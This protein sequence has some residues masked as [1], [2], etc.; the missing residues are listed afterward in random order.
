[1]SAKK[2]IGRLDMI[3]VSTGTIVMDLLE[4]ANHIMDVVKDAEFDD[5]DERTETA[6]A[7]VGLTTTAAGRMV[8]LTRVNYFMLIGL[9]ATNAA[10]IVRE[11]WFV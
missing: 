2:H 5:E 4:Y 3:G 8:N 11:I 9:F 1:M 7:I 6:K 10:W